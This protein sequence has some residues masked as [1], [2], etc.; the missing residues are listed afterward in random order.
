MICLAALWLA[1]YFLH[2]LLASLPAKNCFENLL[3][4][5][6]KYYRL[7][8]NFQSIVFFMLIFWYQKQLPAKWIFIAPTWLAPVGWIIVSIGIV[9]GYVGF[10][11]YSFAEFSGYLQAREGDHY[12]EILKISGLN[13]YVRHPLY[14]ASFVILI[15]WFLQ[16]PGNKNLVFVSISLVYLFVGAWLEEKRLVREFGDQYIKYQKEVKMMIPFIY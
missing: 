7:T 16:W 6:F 12:K 10:R 15:G 5:Y 8:F 9:L 3:P 13:K 1:Y 14:F 4:R 2:S 11:N